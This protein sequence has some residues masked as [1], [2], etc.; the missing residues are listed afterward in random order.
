M[1]LKTKIA[2]DS[3]LTL[4]ERHLHLA[5]SIG[6][7]QSIQ[8]LIHELHVEVNARNA[9]DRT[10][11]HLAAG[12]GHH[13]CVRILYDAGANLE[14]PDKYGMNALLWAAW[15]GHE[16][17]V[18]FLIK[19]GATLSIK[20]KNGLTFLHCA[21]AGGH[22]NV[23]DLIGQNIGEFN[24]NVVDE[25]GQSAI[26]LAVIH[27]KYPAL[28]RLLAHGCDIFVPDKLNCNTAIGEFW[29]RKIYDFLSFW[30]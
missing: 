12:N 27:D 19:S 4:K 2:E 5:A 6:D 20:N 8:L 7:D 18:S 11:L 13:K 9:I 14:H 15:F 1:E 28:L 16:E 30:D 21:A 22:V 24:I 25:K 26:H 23:V 29:S 3:I 10:A 17:I